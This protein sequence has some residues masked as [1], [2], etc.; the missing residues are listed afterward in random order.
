MGPVLAAPELA[1]RLQGGAVAL[2]PTDTLPALAARPEHAAQIWALKDRPAHKPLILMA[3]DLEQF[4]TVLGSPWRRQWLELA[5]RGWPGALT[6]VLPA[7]GAWVH[8]LHPGGQD[9]GL[10]IPACHQARQL[11]R[12]SGPLATTSANP[13]GQPAATTAGQ[14]RQLFPDLPVLAPLSWP[15]AAG[16]AS[17]VL[18]WRDCERGG[19]GRWSLL[20]AGAFLPADLQLES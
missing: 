19:S 4:Q 11:L 6:L 8:W 14:A 17:T 3:A 13:S 16:Q 5:D 7:Q 9:L 18:A 1:L 15:A 10:R 2:M 20:R 12:L